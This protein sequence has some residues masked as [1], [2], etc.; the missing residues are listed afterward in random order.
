[1]LHFGLL[2]ALQTFLGLEIGRAHNFFNMF[3]CS[4]EKAELTVVDKMHPKSAAMVL[5][6]PS[7]QTGNLAR[8]SCASLV[9]KRRSLNMGVGV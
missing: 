8:F 9:P 5:S 1:M 6:F 3:M 4:Y 2:C 7:L